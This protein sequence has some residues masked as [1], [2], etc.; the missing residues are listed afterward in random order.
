M[1]ILKKIIKYFINPFDKKLY[2]IVKGNLKTNFCLLDIGAGGYLNSRWNKIKENLSLISIE[3]NT[4][5]TGYLNNEGSK[6]INKI[7]YSQKKDKMKFYL[8][9]K[10]LCSSIYKP[11]LSY[12]KK[13]PDYDRFSVVK[14]LDIQATTIDEEFKNTKIDF[15]KIDTEGGELDILKGG[16]KSLHN[17]LGLEVE[18]EFFQLRINQP[19]FNEIKLFLENK[20][21]VFVDFLRIS[22]WERFKLRNTGQPQFADVLFL[23]SPESF[24]SELKNSKNEQLISKYVTILCLYNRV[25]YLQ[26]LIE[27]LNSEYVDKFK[28][29]ELLHLVEKKIKRINYIERY[30]LFLKN[31]LS[32]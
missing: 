9:K 25:D 19:L 23:K 4:K 5:S 18:S 27:N 14:E 6:E 30:S 8:Y 10:E 22:R 24:I 26:F 11:N 15:V 21:F 16:E 1:D 29:K 17:L 7:F 12:L 3:P 31:L 32:E 28:I 2:Q 20:G 13:F